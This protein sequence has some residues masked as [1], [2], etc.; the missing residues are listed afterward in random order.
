M[1]QTASIFE[2]IEYN[3]PIPTWF[4]IGGN[5]DKL[6]RPRTVDELRDVLLAFAPDRV[7][8]LGDGANLLV[9][10]DGIDGIVL[11][12][13]H[14]GST[15]EPSADDCE[16]AHIDE[17]WQG[18]P[19]MLRV[20][21]GANLPK[22]IVRC[23]REGLAGLE[24][25]AGIP[26]TI[27]GAVRMN[28]GGAFGEI[29]A[30]VRS[31]HAMSHLGVPMRVPANELTFGYRASGIEHAIITSVELRLTRV[32]GDDRDRLRA[33]LKEVMAYKKKSQPLA[34]KS[35]GCVFKNPLV[36]KN[37]V[38]AGLLIDEAG[39]KGL[40]VGGARVSDRHANFIVTDEHCAAADVLEL[41]ERVREAVKD[42]W[43]VSLENE[44]VVWD[45]SAG[46]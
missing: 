46:P 3:A 27:G 25:L 7:R 33:R 6:V 13:E 39:C 4:G 5:A 24:G 45:R 23:V 17:H 44:L 36:D 37:R 12:L 22:L 34:D 28:A 10:D 1:T 43:G 2:L 19:V 26:A 40:T 20:G 35:A 30:C 11:S 42:E 18:E 9:C 32:A 31:V 16:S 38:S 29:G 14:L 8:V 21:A 15:D 41:M